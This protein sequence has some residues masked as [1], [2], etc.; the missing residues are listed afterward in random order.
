MAEINEDLAAG[1]VADS[2]GDGDFHPPLLEKMTNELSENHK[3]SSKVLT[4]SSSKEVVVPKKSVPK[5][6]KPFPLVQHFSSTPVP[7]PTQNFK[8]PKKSK[9]LDD[10]KL[11]ERFDRM[12]ALMNRHM[13]SAEEFKDTMKSANEQFKEEVM[14]ALSFDD[15]YGESQYSQSYGEEE[16]HDVHPYQAHTMSDDGDD[17]EVTGNQ[18][19]KV[20]ISNQEEITPE[21]DNNDAA[22]ANKSMF[23]EP[24]ASGWCWQRWGR[25]STQQ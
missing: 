23:S 5:V 6:Q 15:Q 2:L 14:H 4:R 8:I 22:Q 20:R 13:V 16:L 21:A 9:P 10:N 18:T 3:K 19:A 24:A 25:K 12:E 7:T 17:M 11:C 1:G